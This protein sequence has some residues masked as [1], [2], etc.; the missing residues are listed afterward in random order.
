[1]TLLRL[2]I[3]G[4]ALGLQKAEDLDIFIV[5]TVYGYKRKQN[6]VIVYESIMS[7]NNRWRSGI[8][9]RMD[10]RQNAEFSISSDLPS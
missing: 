3:F 7:T 1:M 10:Y 4:S 8:E 6:G 9:S 2:N 5:F